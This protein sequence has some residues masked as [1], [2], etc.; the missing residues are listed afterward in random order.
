M[1]STKRIICA[2]KCGQPGTYAAHDWIYP[3]Y[4]R[5]LRAGRPAEGPPAPRVAP[6]AAYAPVR[7][8][9]LARLED[10]VWLREE[11]RLSLD[12]AAVRLHVS[13]RTAERYESARRAQTQ[14]ARAA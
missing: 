1:T 3:C 12:Q 11:L 4:K 6:A 7:A 8:H 2:C 5:W 13:R 14:M 10:Y 9:A